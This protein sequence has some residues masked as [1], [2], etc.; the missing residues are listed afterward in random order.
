MVYDGNS[1]KFSDDNDTINI[2]VKNQGEDISQRILIQNH[3]P[4]SL[5]ITNVRG[6]CGLSVPSW[7]RN[8]IKPGEEGFIIVRY[9]SSRLGNFTRNI[10]IHANTSDSRTVIKLLGEIIP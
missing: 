4:V 1:L 6:G 3:S 5:H 10:T 2:G 9:D 8:I 7:P